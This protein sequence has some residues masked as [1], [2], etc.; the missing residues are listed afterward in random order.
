MINPDIRE[1]NYFALGSENDYGQEALEPKGK[2]RMAINTTSV[3]IQDSV[4]YKDA[5]YIGLT[6]SN[7]LDDK[8]F[9]E[10]GEEMLKVLYIIPRG[11]FN[12]VF[13]KVSAY[14]NQNR[15]S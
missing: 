5:S 12:Q 11:R 3:T 14:G 1:Y 10:F 8:C 9:I 13:L 6:H 7:L 2:V 15:K 4:L